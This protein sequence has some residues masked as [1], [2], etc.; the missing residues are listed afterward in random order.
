MCDHRTASHIRD[1]Q[2]LTKLFCYQINSG[3]TLNV[4][5]DSQL[6][7]TLPGIDHRHSCGRSLEHYGPYF[8]ES[9]VLRLLKSEYCNFGPNHIDDFTCQCLTESI[10]HY[11]IDLRETNRCCYVFANGSIDYLFL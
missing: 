2:I 8:G 7:R 4:S 3:A 5:E 9:R 1:K 10:I 6:S 11:F